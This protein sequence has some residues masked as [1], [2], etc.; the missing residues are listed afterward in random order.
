MICRGKGLELGEREERE[1]QTQG[2]VPTKK[3]KNAASATTC[4]EDRD[5]SRGGDVNYSGKYLT[6]RTTQHH[7][8]LALENLTVSGLSHEISDGSRDRGRD[9]DR[10]RRAVVTEARF[11]TLSHTQHT[12]TYVHNIPSMAASILI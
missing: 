10:D 11:E 2:N 12:Y 4:S 8:S 6:C 7:G 5:F 3:N 1:E 9:R